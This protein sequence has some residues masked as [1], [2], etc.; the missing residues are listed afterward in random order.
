[1]FNSILVKSQVVATTTWP[2]SSPEH[3]SG[4]HISPVLFTLYNGK[5]QGCERHPGR[6]RNLLRHR[7]EQ[8]ARHN[9]VRD[10]VFQTAVQAAG[11]AGQ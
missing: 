4:P 6:P 2:R 8:K 1:M 9:F 11:C 5:V 3:L 10:A 7:G